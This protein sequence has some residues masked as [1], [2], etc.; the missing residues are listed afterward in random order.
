[1]RLLDR[2]V[3]AGCQA[4][5]AGLNEEGCV[6][7]GSSHLDGHPLGR[8]ADVLAAGGLLDPAVSPQAM[9]TYLIVTVNG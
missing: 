7:C 3:D 5:Q 8:D 2:V 9:R 1:M 6:Q 4:R